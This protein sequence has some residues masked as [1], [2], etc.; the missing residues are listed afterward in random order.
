MVFKLYKN[1]SIIC[2]A[3]CSNTRLKCV[4]V[5]GEWFVLK[6]KTVCVLLAGSELAAL[7]NP[8]CFEKL[9]EEFAKNTDVL[10]STHSFS[11]RTL[12]GALGD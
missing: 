5:L 4:G 3:K 6:R 11:N 8:G 1:L 7:R 10:G 2:Y 9:P 12:G